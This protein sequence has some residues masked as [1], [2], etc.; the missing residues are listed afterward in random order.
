[1]V[2]NTARS[3]RDP[4][5][6][7]FGKPSHDEVKRIYYRPFTFTAFKN[8]HEHNKTPRGANNRKGEPTDEGSLK[9]SHGHSR[10]GHWGERKDAGLPVGGGSV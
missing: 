2:T 4:Q 3:W 9:R 7:S 1:M 10:S 5:S 8:A 6:K